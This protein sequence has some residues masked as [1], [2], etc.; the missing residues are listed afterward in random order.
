M[1]DQNLNQYNHSNCDSLYGHFSLIDDIYNLAKYPNLKKAKAQTFILKSGEALLIPKNWWHYVESREKMLGCNFWTSSSLCSV[2]KKIGH[3]ISFDPSLFEDE[4]ISIWKSD[5]STSPNKK[6]KFKDWFNSKTRNE[7]IWCLDNYEG[8]KTNRHI[9]KKLFPTITVPEILS[10]T[11]RNFEFH[12]M[13]CNQ[14]HATNLHYDDQDG[15]LCVSQG[16]KKVILYPPEETK[17]LYPIKF[18][19]Y[20]WVNAPAVTGVYNLCEITK[21]VQ[22]KSSAQLL[23]ETCK[24][25]VGVLSSISNLIKQFHLD[26]YVKI[27]NFLNKE[28]KIN[29]MNKTIFGFKKSIGAKKNDVKW[30]LYNYS[31]NTIKSFEILPERDSKGRYIPDFMDLYLIFH[32]GG[33][34]YKGM[35]RRKGEKNEN[36]GNFILDEFLE[37]EKNFELYWNELNYEN[38]LRNWVKNDLLYKYKTDY[39]CIHQKNNSEFYCQ[40]IGIS[41]KDFLSFLNEYQYSEE[42]INFYEQNE[43]NISNEITLVFDK[44]TKTPLR[45]A[46]YGVV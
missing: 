16:E 21:E 14:F 7:Y 42:L 32:P 15:V 1:A 17:N 13:A 26:P 2:P 25:N 41:N 37:F 29:T 39:F 44:A 3:K 4:L 5:K 38:D 45:T 19:K 23:F 9:A 28:T 24:D 46:F 33:K 12:F 20:P 11:N 36:R 34:L 40:F 6:I 22:G 8:L 18:E 30:E 27:A 43:F 31:K 10:S 35:I